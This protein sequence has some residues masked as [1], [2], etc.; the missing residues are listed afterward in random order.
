MRIDVDHE[1]AMPI[2]FQRIIR[3]AAMRMRGR[4]SGPTVSEIRGAS[5][6]TD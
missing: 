2:L 4:K 6:S 5:A 1:E 3:F